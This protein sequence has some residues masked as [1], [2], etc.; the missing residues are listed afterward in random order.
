[1]DNEKTYSVKLK[2]GLMPSA[3]DSLGKLA[4][5]G[6]L[7]A[8]GIDSLRNLESNFTGLLLSKNPTELFIVEEIKNHQWK[9]ILRND[10]IKTDILN[11]KLLK[12][13]K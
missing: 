9:P 1:M 7:D 5:K 10:F 11:K 13:V 8:C 12:C 6:Q 2:Q 3:I 4:I